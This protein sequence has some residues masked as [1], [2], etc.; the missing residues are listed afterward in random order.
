MLDTAHHTPTMTHAWR[1]DVS[2]GD[3]VYFRFPLSEDG[4]V[5]EHEARPCLILDIEVHG[6]LRYAQLACGAASHRRSGVSQQIHVRRRAEYAP[7]GLN[8]PTCFMGA[9]RLLVPLTHAGFV[10]ASV[11]ESPVLGRLDGQPF[12]QMN[13]VR[14]RIHALRDMHTARLRGRSSYSRRGQAAGREFTVALRLSRHPDAGAVG[15][16][17]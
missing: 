8:A 9:R 11:T 6:G 5:S 17:S 4:T 3:I 16:R 1:D 13:A 10:E 7:A 15:D 14:G 12:A 2:Y